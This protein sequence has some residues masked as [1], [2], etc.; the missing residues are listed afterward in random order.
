MLFGCLSTNV[1]KNEV[2][3]TPWTAELKLQGSESCY[4]IALMFCSETSTEII[5]KDETLQYIK[6]VYWDYAFSLFYPGAITF[7]IR[8]KDNK[9]IFTCERYGTG[10]LNMKPTKKDYEKLEQVAKSYQVRMFQYINN[11]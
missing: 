8:V 2:V 6:G 4:N 1:S 3:T 7:N 9:L 5:S 10:T 11:F